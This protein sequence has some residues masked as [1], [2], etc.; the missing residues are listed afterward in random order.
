M[1]QAKHSLQKSGPVILEGYRELMEEEIVQE[2][3]EE[4]LLR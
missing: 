4:D 2:D 1:T 3:E